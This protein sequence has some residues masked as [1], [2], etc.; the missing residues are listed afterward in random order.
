M[1]SKIQIYS[2]G[3]LT[4]A[5]RRISLALIIFSAVLPCSFSQDTLQQGFPD[6][7]VLKYDTLVQVSDSIRADTLASASAKKKK[8]E[9]EA[10]VKYS[11]E[12]SF[13][14]VISEQRIYLYK[15]AKVDYQNIDL[16]SDYVEFDM[17][18]STVK[19][20]G[21]VDTSGAIKGKPVFTQENEK[22]DSDTL[23]Y[24]FKSRKGVIKNVTTKQGD[25][26]LQSKQTKRMADGEINVK[27][28]KYTT[29]DAAHP[30]FY[31]GLT[32]AIAI[33]NDK[34]V[35]GP[36]YLVVEDVP[37]P[38]ALPFGF[39]PNTT[40]RASGII[41]PKYGEEKNRGFFLRDGGLYL[42]LNDYFDLTVLGTVYSRGTWGVS[43]STGYK[44]RYKYNG[45]LYAQYYRNT[46]K[47]GN[48]TER[49]GSR[50]FKI[51]WTH[52]QDPK[53]NPTRSFSA[54]VDFATSGYESNHGTNMND[55]LT[56]TKTSSISYSKNW[57][58][59]PFNFTASMNA[60]QNSQTKIVDLRLPTMTF[61]VNRLY[62][63]RSRKSSGS[64]K[65][66]QNIQ[67]S[68]NSKLD[69]R[70]SS[71]DST[72]FTQQTL[73]NMKN[74]F[75]H[76]IP[77]S[78]TNIKLLNLINITPG[79]SYDGV[80]YTSHI[81][82]SFPED[83][84]VY[85]NATSAQTNIDTIKG[86][87]YAQALK[88]SIGI[89]ASPKIYMRYTSKKEDSYF[90]ALRHVMTPNASLSYVPD[91]SSIMPNY[92]KVYS[93]P[94]T[95][96][97][98]AHVEEYS[99]Y[100]NYIYGTP[101]LPGQS[102][103]IGL[104]LNNNVEMKV[105]PKNDTT[106]KGKKVSILDNLNFSVNYNPFADEFK[107]S[108]VNMTGATRLFNNKM[109]VTFGANFDPYTTDPVKK[110]R[111]DKF[112]YRDNGKLLRTTRAYI[113]AGFSLQSKAGKK[114]SSGS[115]QEGSSLDD[116]STDKPIVENPVEETQGPYANDYVDFNVPWTLRVEYS[117]SYSRPV[118]DATFSHT[119]R[120]SGDVSLT[121]K[122]KIGGNT[123]YDFIG[124][125]VSV[126]NLSIHRDL[127]CWEM[128]F[129]VIPFGKMK[130]YSFSINA[131]TAILR[132]L[133]YDKRKSWYDNF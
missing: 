28:G 27:G 116:M 38:L 51:R 131:K 105:R 16:V 69:N 107:W 93:Y 41:I 54:N 84:A 52:T 7:L 106:G 72:L 120:I 61:N 123:G 22:F 130:S 63:F 111:I 104:G 37:V 30:H 17:D 66:F 6:T 9:L 112:L 109:N 77:V 91:L 79:L 8:T 13:R 118:N 99:A 75:S 33:P 133:K 42:A 49:A 96:T 70:I 2:R 98:P 108:T 121:P 101:V 81:N 103:S 71:P 14:I 29:C 11:A 64:M 10:E 34:I 127:H 102:G 56:N 57:P 90:I 82:K 26:F 88:P 46:V 115:G 122:W 87:T 55:Y 39:F 47:D 58:G 25:G 23:M 128:R 1:I 67:I 85:Y 80:L 113:N 12:D 15:N 76:S 5:Q 97:Q 53:A 65:W 31:I 74:G 117:W 110:V 35:S 94:R 83:S 3:L 89:S 73:D 129:T 19:A 59:R 100:E 126:T 124:R 18:N 36:A 4:T 45:S 68:Y 62:P 40:E 24:N 95:I 43:T 119:I 60:S 114:G 48:E 92:Y 20:S 86:I 44:K 32:K 132:D 50:D 21:L 125:Q 78:L